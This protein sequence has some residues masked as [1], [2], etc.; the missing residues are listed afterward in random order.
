MKEIRTYSFSQDHLEIFHSKIRSRNGHNSNLNAAQFKGAFRRLTSQMEIKAPASSNCMLFDE[1]QNASFG[2]HSN[3]YFISLKRP[4]VNLI[5]D[6]D[7]RRNL[8][9]QQDQIEEE[10]YALEDPAETS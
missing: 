8:E 2:L 1:E 7:F 6:F 3:V 9:L 4:K 10:Y 5:N